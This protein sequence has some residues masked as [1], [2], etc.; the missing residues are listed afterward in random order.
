[1]VTAI[2]SWLFSDATPIDV[3]QSNV[4]SVSRQHLNVT[5]AWNSSLRTMNSTAA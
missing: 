1:M 4:E 3:I 5:V 2:H